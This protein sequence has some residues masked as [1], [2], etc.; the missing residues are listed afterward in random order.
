MIKQSINSILDSKT[1]T[2][3]AKIKF[4]QS[5][6][7]IVHSI[8]IRLRSIFMR[9]IMAAKVIDQIPQQAFGFN[10]SWFV[11]LRKKFELINN[12]SSTK[13]NLNSLPTHH[14]ILTQAR[15]LKCAKRPSANKHRSSRYHTLIRW[16]T[17]C[18]F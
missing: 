9:D 10:N 1:L 2:N 11:L 16:R 18:T 5:R 14:T 15:L 7:Y 3:D 4:T 8:K 13:P 12:K 17:F 6:W